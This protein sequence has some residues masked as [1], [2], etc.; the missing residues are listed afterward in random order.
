MYRKNNTTSAIP[1]YTVLPHSLIMQSQGAAMEPTDRVLQIPYIW[2]LCILR[3]PL[4]KMQAL[5]VSNIEGGNSCI[6]VHSYCAGVAKCSE[7]R[8]TLAACGLHG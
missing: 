1:T 2:Q 4:L 3:L 6:E 7:C 5:A 8:Y